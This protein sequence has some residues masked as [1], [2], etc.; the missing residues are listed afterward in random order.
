MTAIAEDT[1][2]HLAAS[3]AEART[4]RIA[5]TRTA[6]AGAMPAF[7][8]FVGVVAVWEA[9]SRIFKLPEFELHEPTSIVQDLVT[10]KL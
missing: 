10:L 1:R 5:R 6:L 2:G 3:E 7:A 9:V 4:G 8:L